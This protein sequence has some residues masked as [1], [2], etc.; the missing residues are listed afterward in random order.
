MLL[1]LVGSPRVVLLEGANFN[2]NYKSLKDSYL[3][4]IIT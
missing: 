1:K 2:I 3:L 4:M